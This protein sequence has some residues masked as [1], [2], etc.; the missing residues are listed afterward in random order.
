MYKQMSTTTCDS[1]VS[2]S[3][4]NSNPMSTTRSSVQLDYT[5]MN[6]FRVVSVAVLSQPT[7]RPL[8][9]TTFLR[10]KHPLPCAR[11]PEVIFNH[12]SRL[13]AQ[14]FEILIIGR[15]QS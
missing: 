12:R 5:E 10:A 14:D 13:G 1:S 15:S 4:A 9:F 2:V 7:S 8:E 11:T 3:L 6:D